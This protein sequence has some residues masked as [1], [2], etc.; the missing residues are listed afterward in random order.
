MNIILWFCAFIFCLKGFTFD[1]FSEEFLSTQI[2]TAQREGVLDE[3][4]QERLLELSALK[5]TWEPLINEQK[6]LHPDFFS[7]F[8]DTLET[9]TLALEPE[10][11]GG[12][13]ILYDSHNIPQFIIKPVDED[14]FCLHNPKHFASPFFATIVCRFI[15][16][17][18]NSTS[19][20][21]KGVA[22]VLEIAINTLYKII[23]V[24]F[25]R[26]N[27]FNVS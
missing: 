22:F 5:K 15:Y 8:S 26:F 14:I 23:H 13:Y 18:T 1:R 3:L 4:I 7:S 27:Q 11:M 25:A 20:S 16:K 12:T 24:L 21:F 10:G 6:L 17:L 2:S 9:G 19:P